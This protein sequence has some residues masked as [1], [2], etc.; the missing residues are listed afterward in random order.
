LASSSPTP[1]RSEIGD[2]TTPVGATVS[3]HIEESL[4]DSDF[5]AGYDRLRPHEEFARIVLR[6][7]AALGLSQADLAARMGVAASTVSRVESGQH[8]TDF[9]TLKKLGEAF[10]VCAVVGFETGAAETARREIVAL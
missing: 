9:R 2:Q 4:K 3:D 7:R 10:G 5:R 8:P 6:R 1:H